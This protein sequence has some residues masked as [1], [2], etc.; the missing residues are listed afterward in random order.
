M[1][2]FPNNDI[3]SYASQL[4]AD[5]SEIIKGFLEKPQIPHVI[6]DS[7]YAEVRNVVEPFLAVGMDIDVAQYNNGLPLFCIQFVP[8]HKLTEQELKDLT[9]RI[10]IKFRRY[11]TARGFM[12]YNFATFKSTDYMVEVTIYYA[13]FE[14]D[15]DNLK[16]LYRRTL[17]EKS[18]SDYGA[19][20]DDDLDKELKEHRKKQ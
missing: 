5:V 3:K 4:R 8:S 20:R 13:E 9:E 1:I 14:K 18:G 10:K 2:R 12:W 6:E 15:I 19:L 11:L 16:N 17:I 7:L